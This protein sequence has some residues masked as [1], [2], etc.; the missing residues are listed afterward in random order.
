MQSY[1]RIFIRENMLQTNL[2]VYTNSRS[3]IRG[4]DRRVSRLRSK[5]RFSCT[6]IGKCSILKV[7]CFSF[8]SQPDFYRRI[9]LTPRPYVG[10]LIKLNAGNQGIRDLLHII[11]LHPIQ[12]DTAIMIVILRKNIVCSPIKVVCS[13]I[14]CEP[15][16]IIL[17]KV[18]ANGFSVQRTRVTYFG[19][20][21]IVLSVSDRNSGT[22]RIRTSM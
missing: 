21:E 8:F 5:H 3:G 2:V 1:Y 16:Q 20:K 6:I 17:C 7:V 10:L 22:I 14:M 15:I 13:L 19:R 11:N 4:I 9:V 18:R 12:I